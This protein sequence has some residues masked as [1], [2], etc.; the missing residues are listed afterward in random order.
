MKT[1]KM[2]LTN[3]A[4]LLF[5][6]RYAEIH[7]LFG[8]IKL[9]DPD[10]QY[11]KFLDEYIT[12]IVNNTI[13]LNINIT[14]TNGIITDIDK[15]YISGVGLEWITSQ[16]RSHIKNSQVIKINLICEFY[17]Y[18][19][20]YYPQGVCQINGVHII[21]KDYV[22][23]EHKFRLIGC[24]NM[25]KCISPWL[26][27]Q[28]NKYTIISADVKNETLDLIMNNI[29]NS[30]LYNLYQYVELNLSK[31]KLLVYPDRTII[32]NKTKSAIKPISSG[33]R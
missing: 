19:G 23:T 28:N 31:N 25:G 17:L 22:H 9:L 5:A 16:I 21:D 6:H 33:R 24:I 32:T 14:L 4:D 11:T 20:L 12:E 27:I 3:T 1:I 18:Q 13:T 8:L 10:H 30:N 2:N 15:E 29:R 26:M 7:Q